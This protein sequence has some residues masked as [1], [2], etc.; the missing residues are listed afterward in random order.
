MLKFSTYG[1]WA[2]AGVVLRGLSNSGKV[3]SV[4][5]SAVDADGNMIKSKLVGHIDAQ[6]LGWAPLS[7]HTVALKGHDKIFVET[8]SLR[9]GIRV[10]A[11][12]APSNGY[13]IFIGASPWVKNTDGRK[14]SDIM[15]YLEY[16]TSKMPARPLI[17]PTWNEVK[18]KVK[19]D[20]RKTLHGLIRGGVGG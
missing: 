3:K 1:D 10:R 12:R 14:L 11:I 20:M 19:A 9:A 18:D 5:K 16:G 13:S 2:K 7:P 6:D 4:F 8:G 17:R 15:R